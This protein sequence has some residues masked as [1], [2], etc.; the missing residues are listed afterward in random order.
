MSDT[1]TWMEKWRF[2][3]NIAN[4][5][6][7]KVYNWKDVHNNLPIDKLIEIVKLTK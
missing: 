1:S 2:Y 7:T 3:D 5:V 6:F 4:V